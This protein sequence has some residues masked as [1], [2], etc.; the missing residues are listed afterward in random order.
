MEC[1]II[2]PYK[3][4]FL[5]PFSIYLLYHFFT[6]R[7]LWSHTVLHPLLS[8]YSKLVQQNFLNLTTFYSLANRPFDIFIL[9][10]IFATCAVLAAYEPLPNQDTSETNDKLV[11]KFF[12][13]FSLAY[14]YFYTQKHFVF[15]ASSSFFMLPQWWWPAGFPNYGLILKEL[16]IQAGDTYVLVLTL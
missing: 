2:H 15:K 7:L 5:T 11:R 8:V 14:F 12:T 16:T 9:L 13:L 6:K 3:S 1:N 10:N 4:I